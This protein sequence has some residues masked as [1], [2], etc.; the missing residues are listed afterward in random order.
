[1][2]QTLVLQRGEVTASQN[3]TTLLFT[4]TASGTATRMVVGYLSWASDFSTV[5]GRCTFGVLRSGEVSPNFT[6]FA[7]SSGGTSSSF[8]RF[9]TFLPSDHTSSWHG[10]INNAQENSVIM[11]SNSAGTNAF[12]NYSCLVT[13]GGGSAARYTTD[14]MLGPSDEVHV[15][16]NDN[17][18]NN[19]AAVIQFCILLVTE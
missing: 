17:G 2:A 11:H 6:I 3:T 12:K 19:R 5:A 10:N 4:N 18:G 14:V 16:W 13:F 8:N 1:M 7:G 15:S 9:I